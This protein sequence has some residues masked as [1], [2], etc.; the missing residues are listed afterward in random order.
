MNAHPQPATPTIPPGGGLGRRGFLARALPVAAAAAFAPALLDACSTGTTSS[1]TS[2]TSTLK[3]SIGYDFPENSLPVYADLVKFA[4]ARASQKG[5]KLLL[6]A[7]NGQQS[8][9]IANVQAW[10]TEGVGGMVVFPLEP[11]TM[12]TMAE[13]AMHKG[14][15]WVVYG[16]TMQHQ[17]GSIEFSPYQGGYQLGSYAAAWA[18]RVLGGKGKAAFLIN[19]TIDLTRQRDK[20]VQ[21]SF[22]KLAPGMQVVA[23]Q[24]ANSE[25][26]G[27]AATDAMLTAHPDIN[28]LLAVNDDGALGAYQSF[29]AK[30]IS[31]TDPH[32]FIGG[33]DGTQQA[34]ATIKK[35]G[36]FRATSAVRIKDIGYAIVDLPRQILQGGKGGRL[37]LPI[38][39]ISATSPDLDVYLSDYS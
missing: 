23:K 17:S 38:K 31:P 28:I 20:G 29:L 18:H 26:T 27:L 24:F 10:I 13:Q 35:N 12:E 37:N 21:D 39:V 32:V 7:D 36:I 15:V 33:Q 11:S 8:A 19:E 34:L 9:E 30:G 22:T 5:C 16:G 1:S 6:S 4:Q 3:T 14:L 25:Q 2:A